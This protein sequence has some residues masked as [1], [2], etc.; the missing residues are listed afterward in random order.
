MRPHIFLSYSHTDAD[1]MRRLR[2]DLQAAGLNIWTDERLKPGTPGWD[3]AIE[4]NIESSL[5]II[6]ILSPTAKHSQWVRTEIHYA[7]M[8]KKR[9]F[10]ILMKGDEMTSVPLTLARTHYIDGRIGYSS[11]LKNLVSAIA[12]F[13]GKLP[14]VQSQGHGADKSRQLI[15]RIS[16]VNSFITIIVV[17]DVD[18]TRDTIKQILTFESD[19]KVVGEAS[20][21]QQGILLATELLPDIVLMDINMPDVDGIAATGK[22]LKAVPKAAVIMLSVQNDQ[23]YVRRAMLAGARSYLMKPVIADQLCSTVREVYQ[24]N[25]LRL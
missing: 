7:T 22:I 17:D 25:K 8:H 2:D 9:V 10:P 24:A 6:V 5:C 1:V 13:Q 4:Q 18:E 3:D 23:E 21:G 14:V 20:T 15:R 16:S 19:F 12:E 11:A